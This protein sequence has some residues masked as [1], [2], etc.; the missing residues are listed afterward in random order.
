MAELVKPLVKLIQ[1][2]NG[3]FQFEGSMALCNLA[4]CDEDLRCVVVAVMMIVFF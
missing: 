1:E 2:R 4:S 3:L